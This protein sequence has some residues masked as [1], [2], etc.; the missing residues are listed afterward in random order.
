MNIENI[1]KKYLLD[2]G[3]DHF[4]TQKFLGC[5]LNNLE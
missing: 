2:A 4:T 3:S 1:F 5:K